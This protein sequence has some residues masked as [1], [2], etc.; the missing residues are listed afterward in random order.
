MR[1]PKQNTADRFC[2]L[3]EALDAAREYSED[4]GY[5]VVPFVCSHCS[6]GRN[7]VWHLRAAAEVDLSKEQ[8]E[9]RI[10]VNDFI[11]STRASLHQQH[12]QA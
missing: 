6:A 1:I 10:Q 5:V 9:I 7:P 2:S 11:Q 4:R 12:A 3:E 8:E